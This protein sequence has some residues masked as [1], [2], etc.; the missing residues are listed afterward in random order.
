M[1][2]DKK[3]AIMQISSLKKEIALAKLTKK[4]IG[5]KNLSSLIKENKKKVARLLTELNAKK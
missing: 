4:D 2:I 3:D 1:S 5:S